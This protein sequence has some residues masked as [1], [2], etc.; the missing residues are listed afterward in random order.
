MNTATQMV[1]LFIIF[2]I[3]HLSIIHAVSLLPFGRQAP[4]YSGGGPPPSRTAVP[5]L[6]GLKTPAYS[7]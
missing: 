6:L 5:R 4:A 1:R 2:L 7:D 3:Y